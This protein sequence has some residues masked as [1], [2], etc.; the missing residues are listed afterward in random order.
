MEDQ[1]QT[2]ELVFVTSVKSEAEG[3]V[4]QL[5]ALTSASGEVTLSKLDVDE[6]VGAVTSDKIITA[7]LA[8]SLNIA[9]GALGNVVYNAFQ[10]SP[11]VHCVAG[12]TPLNRTDDMAALEAKLRAAA[13]PAAGRAADH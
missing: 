13:K 1:L 5:R 7:V 3:L 8:F 2:L 9:A 12:E 10:A 11:S 6:A 4:R